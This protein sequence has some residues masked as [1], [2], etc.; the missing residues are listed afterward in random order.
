[1]PKEKRFGYRR[2]ELV[3]SGFKTIRDTAGHE[4]TQALR[5]YTGPQ[6]RVADRSSYSAWRKAREIIRCAILSKKTKRIRTLL[7]SNLMSTFAG[8]GCEE[9]T[10]RPLT[11]AHPGHTRA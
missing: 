6:E 4:T 11:N 3:T 9:R 5:K 2:L 8:V 10:G 7:S 1:M